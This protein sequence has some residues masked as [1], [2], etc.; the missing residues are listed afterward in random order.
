MRLTM[1]NVLGSDG[2][3]AQRRPFLSFLTTG[4]VSMEQDLPIS[5]PYMPSGGRLQVAARIEQQ[6]V[7]TFARLLTEVTPCAC[8]ASAC[9][10]WNRCHPVAVPAH[11]RC[12]LAK[13]FHIGT[14]MT[15]A[16]TSHP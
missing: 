16:F 12:G 13:R 4:T 14:A 15:A 8:H 10:M 2:G 9:S 5:K 6:T 3:A 11:T 7:V 1:R